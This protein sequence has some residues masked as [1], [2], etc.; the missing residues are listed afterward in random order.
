MNLLTIHKLMAVTSVE[1]LEQELAECLLGYLAFY[2]DDD[3][4]SSRSRD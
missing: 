2:L 1:V 4:M 3:W